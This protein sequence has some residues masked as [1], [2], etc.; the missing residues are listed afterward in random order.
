MVDAVQFEV[1]TTLG[2]GVGSVAKFAT[3]GVAANLIRGSTV[4]SSKRGLALPVGNRQFIE[5]KGK[6]LKRL[7]KRYAGKLKL[8]ILDEFSMLRQKELHWV[9]KRLKQ[10]M[11]N[12]LPFGGVAIVLIG[13][14]GQLPAILG[15]SLIHI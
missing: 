3:S 7:Q 9:D 6:T 10:I 11:G 1:E 12:N 2:Y 8:V 14:P 4:H 15:L 5:L 13:D